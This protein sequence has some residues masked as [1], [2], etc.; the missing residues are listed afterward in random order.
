MFQMIYHLLRMPTV[1]VRKNQPNLRDSRTSLL[2]LPCGAILI[3]ER[4]WTLQ[5]NPLSNLFSMLWPVETS[6]V[7]PCHVPT[8]HSTVPLCYISRQWIN[9]TAETLFVLES[10][11]FTMKSTLRW[12]PLY[13]EL[14]SN[15]Q[16]TPLNIAINCISYFQ[17]E[18]MLRLVSVLEKKSLYHLFLADEP[19]PARYCNFP[20]I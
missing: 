10:G 5:K 20:R 6:S 4:T 15:F 2:R 7:V 12:L 1:S 9:L 16:D 8:C 14:P 3:A 19:L 13:S 11:D 18:M 17:A